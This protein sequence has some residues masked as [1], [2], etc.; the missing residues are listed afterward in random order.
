[1]QT[2]KIDLTKEVSLLSFDADLCSCQRVTTDLDINKDGKPVTK[3]ATVSIPVFDMTHTNGLKTNRE[4]IRRYLQSVGIPFAGAYIVAKSEVKEIMAQCEDYVDMFNNEKDVLLRDYPQLLADF[5]DNYGVDEV[6]PIIEKLAYSADVFAA[7]HSLEMLPAMSLG[8][9]DPDGE[10]ALLNKISEAAFEDV[11]TS[12][13]NIYKDRLSVG[14]PS[15][16][17]TSATQTV[18]K[19]LVAL[20]DKV[21]KLSFLH[22]GLGN[23]IKGF[24]AVLSTLPKTGKIEGHH[25]TNV[26]NLVHSLRDKDL[27]KD[28]SDGA[29]VNILETADDWIDSEVVDTDSSVDTTP[30]P[31]NDT[32]TSTTV[33]NEN[34]MPGELFSEDDLF[35]GWD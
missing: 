14:K 20:K 27:L 12:A 6:K 2:N 9:A 21:T 8:A 32:S 34:P 19:D 24:D 23:L 3:G 31:S 16:L 22:E 25:L 30:L 18:A 5:I 26:V 35:H 4:R 1:M 33:D 11:R 29:P 10:D 13:F 15:M 17:V 28:L 7:K